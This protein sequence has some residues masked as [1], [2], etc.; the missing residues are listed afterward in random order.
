MEE[1]VAEVV[2]IVEVSIPGVVGRDA[3]TFPLRRVKPEPPPPQGIDIV[4]LHGGGGQGWAACGPGISYGGSIRI[5][6][7][8]PSGGKVTVSLSTY[9]MLAA[10][11]GGF[12]REIDV[13]WMGEV[14]D[15]A[16]GGSVHAFFTP[17]GKR[18][19]R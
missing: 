10:D 14:T 16:A 12:D 5:L 1:A 11:S 9:W 7:P 4:R 8:I 18:P 15:I 3:H 2:L 13:P 6:G 19:G 17:P